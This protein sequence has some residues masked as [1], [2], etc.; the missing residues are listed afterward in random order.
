MKK[1]YLNDRETESFY[2]LL[3]IKK[4]L[5]TRALYKVKIPR[6]L[7]HEFYNYG[8]EGLLVSFL[9]L[10]EGKIEEK[11]FDRFA[12]TTIKRKLIDEIRYRNKDKS[13]PLDIFDNNR[14]DATDDNYSF[15]YIQLFEYLKD[16]LDEQELKFF[17]EFIKS[18]DIKKTA[19]AMHISLRTAYRIHKRIKGV[20]ESFLLSR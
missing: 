12:F 17:C 18:L 15:V 9:I 10:N 5:I 11:D 20:C 4:D 19:E 13:I 6:K 16:T 2:E 3:E 1:Y 7:H 14:K 8:L